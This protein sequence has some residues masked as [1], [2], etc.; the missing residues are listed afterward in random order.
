MKAKLKETQAAFA[1]EMSGHLYFN[2]R[3][4]GLDDG[5]YAAARLLEIISRAPN[6]AAVTRLLNDLPQGI[7]TPE[8]TLRLAEGEGHAI[9][10][11]LAQTA[12]F[13]DATLSTVD[14]L[15][16][17]Y[18]DGFGLVRASNTTPALVLRFE[19]N[20]VLGLQ[21]IQNEFK[22]LLCGVKPDINLP[23]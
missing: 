19:A 17:D 7:S 5:L 11:I 4:G 14:G 23:F 8:I 21:R 9:M 18:A 10:S 22:K 6:E 16:A 12:S 15:R 13:K 1:G 2:D 3:W 20:D